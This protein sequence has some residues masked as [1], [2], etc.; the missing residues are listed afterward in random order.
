MDATALVKVSGDQRWQKC[1]GLLLRFGRVSA[2][3]R[4]YDFGTIPHMQ[5]ALE[6][7]FRCF[8]HNSWKGHEPN[9]PPGQDE[10]KGIPTP[11]V[12][13]IYRRSGRR[14]SGNKF[15]VTFGGAECDG[16]G[17]CWVS[18]MLGEEGVKSLQ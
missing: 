16:I 14:Y 18:C 11:K 7:Q 9:P 13:G 6:E 4:T 1:K 10:A 17:Y 15:G 12:G 5:L 8:P 2:N 3:A